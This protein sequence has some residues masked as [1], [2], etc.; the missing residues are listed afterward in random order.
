[1]INKIELNQNE[2]MEKIPV[3]KGDVI[4]VK[5]DK[6]HRPAIR[7]FNDVIPC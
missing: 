6:R 4:F 1:M 3:Q 5:Y 7:V 2:E